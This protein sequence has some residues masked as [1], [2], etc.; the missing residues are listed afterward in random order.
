MILNLGCGLNTIEG[1]INIDKYLK[2][3]CRADIRFLPFKDG[4]VDKIYLFHVIEHFSYHQHTELLQEMWRVL[5]I[6]G[7]LIISYPEFIKCAENYASNKNGKREFWR[8][9]IFGRQAHTGDAHLALMD[10]FFFTQLLRECCFDNI[11]TFS[12]PKDDYNS[13]VKCVKANLF[14]N[15]IDRYKRDYFGIECSPGSK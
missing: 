13:V 11:K 4:E 9:T 12:E 14:P 5:K 1:T 8:A 15:I 7:E 3:D 6:G 10:T 2:S